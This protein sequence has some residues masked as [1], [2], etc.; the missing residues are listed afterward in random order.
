MYHVRIKFVSCTNYPIE[1][2]NNFMYQTYIFEFKFNLKREKNLKSKLFL[3][4]PSDNKFI[5]GNKIKYFFPLTFRSYGQELAYGS[6]KKL[7]YNGTKF[8][9]KNTIETFFFFERKPLLRKIF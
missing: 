4:Y 1:C 8:Q 9:G 6:E 2:N 5:L 7:F 3:T